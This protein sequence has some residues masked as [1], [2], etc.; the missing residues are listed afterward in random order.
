[1]T[2]SIRLGLQAN[3]RQFWLL[4]ALN[5]F[6]G[7]MV[8]LER[9]VLP[10]VGER[11]FG[12]ASKSAIVSFVV[13]F[14]AAKALANLGAGELVR[15]LGR[16]RVLVLGWLLALPVS[17]LV[18]LAPG[19]EWIVAA[20]V[21]LGASQ[22]L[23]WSLTILMKLDLVGPTRRGL[24]LGLN[25]SAG[26]AGMAVSAFATGALAATFAPRALVWVGA[27]ALAGVGLASSLLFVRDTT[28]FARLEEEVGAPVVRSDRRLRS[29][30]QAGFMNNLN[31]ALAW[32]LAPLYLA[33]NGA[34]AKQIGAVAAVY[35]AAWAAGQVAVGWLSDRFGRKRF[36]VAGMLTQAGALSLLA[37]SARFPA[38]LA[39]AVV[40]GLGTALVYPTLVAAVS[41]NV[42]AAER[43]RALARY[44]FWR[45]SGLVAGA[46]LTGLLA[47]VLGSG[48]AILLV[49]VLTAATGAWVAATYSPER[50]AA[51]KT[52]SR[53]ATTLGVRLG[54]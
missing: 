22:G 33:A 46:L 45:D 2:P 40:L 26:Y 47:D 53:P 32:A 27:A 14:G 11:E 41:D 3:A 20:N 51:S 30:S 48:Q 13:A 18:A 49:A 38:A 1:M 28:A 9:S 34:T 44:R 17:A 24:A 10:L 5:C 29:C 39:A 19:W 4:V 36:I 12:I 37:T 8:G 42:S 25:E 31:D 23:A 15:R 54:Q 50:W 21:F 43:P 52:Q 35:P 7:A 16:K 6:V